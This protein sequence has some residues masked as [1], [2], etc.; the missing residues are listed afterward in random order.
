MSEQDRPSPWDAIRQGFRDGMER[1]KERQ[2]RRERLRR[3]AQ[4]LSA[5]AVDEMLIDIEQRMT[6]LFQSRHDWGDRE[7]A[8]REIELLMDD[9]LTVRQER[10]TRD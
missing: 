8:E 3:E 7:T 9:W 2:E 4:E 6:G 10:L 5:A 1:G